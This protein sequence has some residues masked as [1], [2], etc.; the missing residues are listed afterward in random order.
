MFRREGGMA[1][2]ELIGGAFVIAVGFTLFYLFADFITGDKAE[3]QMR[4]SN[5]LND[6]ENVVGIHT[7]EEF[8]S[9]I[10]TFKL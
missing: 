7:G 5:Y 4:R 6:G 10:I 3:R 1:P 9:F 8:G 2:F